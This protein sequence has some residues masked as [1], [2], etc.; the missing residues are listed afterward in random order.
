MLTVVTWMW[1][2]PGRDFDAKHVR[3]LAH[4]VRKNLTVPHEFIC[5]T[6]DP[7]VGPGV[8][9]FKTPRNALK[10]AE[11][12][13]PEGVNFPACYRRLWLFSEEA[14]MIGDRF[15]L[16]DLDVVVVGNIDHIAKMEGSFV[17]WV[18][19]EST[20]HGKNR[21]GGG[22]YLLTA[23]AHTDV[24]TDFTGSKSIAA[25]RSAGYRGSDQAWINHKL[26][27]KHPSFSHEAG[28]VMSR[29]LKPPHYHLPRNTRV[30][31]FSGRIKPWHVN[32]HDVT[33]LKE[34]WS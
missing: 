4:C 33:W 16:L 32:Q 11:Y 13:S 26:Y 28:V 3:R 2:S 34:A 17:G 8:I 9:T 31:Q 6:S 15:L 27:G 20:W 29:E 22:M 1:H 21:F 19:G 5:I 23:G 24:Y 18:P 30:V 12:K 10:L 14:K 7:P 25:A